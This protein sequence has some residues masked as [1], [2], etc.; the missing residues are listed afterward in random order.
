MKP[1]L[2]IGP[3]DYLRVTTRGAIIKNQH[4]FF[5]LQ[6]K[7]M[8]VSFVDTVNFR[9]NPLIIIK[10]LFMI[11]ISKH[12]NIILAT[13]SSS[14]YN[15]VRI[16]SLFKIKRKFIYWV[17]G[18]D[19]GNSLINNEFGDNYFSNFAKILVEGKVVKKEFEANGIYNS[20][21][22][23]NFRNILYIPKKKSQLK[24]SRFVFFSRISPEKGVDLI[25]KCVREI[26][27]IGY[28]KDYSIDIY[29]IIEDSYKEYFLNQLKEFKNVSFKGLLDLN[30]K[31]NYNVLASYDVL[32]FPTY[33]KGEG[34][35][36]VL[37]DAYIAGLPVVASNWNLN[38][39]VIIDGYSGVLIKPNSVNELKEIMISFLDGKIDINAMSKNCQ[40][41][42][43]KYKVE[44]VLNDKLLKEIGLL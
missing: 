2:F 21:V 42:C 16:L 36:G 24:T 4:L 22:I 28:D 25:L 8:N 14:T 13:S 17:V 37:I 40:S 6:K 38:S 1:I 32:L 35:P 27:H 11:L 15:L 20:I 33:F 34:F 39:E 10:I 31:T 43:L 3:L 41:M 18:G 44:N 5:F 23:P 9:K 7:F 29:G 12:K 26:N 30:V 19:I